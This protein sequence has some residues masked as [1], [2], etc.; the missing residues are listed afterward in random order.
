MQQS[1]ENKFWRNYLQQMRFFV[2]A[3]IELC[4]PLQYISWLRKAKNTT[5]IQW[6][7]DS[8]IKTDEWETNI[9]SH[10]M[11]NDTT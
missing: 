8:V 11:T 4:P 9:R 7:S 1:A 3:S 10:I 5:A 2:L 6:F